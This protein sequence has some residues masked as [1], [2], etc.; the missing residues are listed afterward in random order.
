MLVRF[1]KE[2][3]HIVQ[4]FAITLESRQPE[5]IVYHYTND[6][7][8]RGILE[9]GCLWLTDIFSLNDLT[10]GFQQEVEHRAECL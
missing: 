4:A 8:L 1:A 5:P 6:V 7:G 2:A 3:D 10:P 9:S